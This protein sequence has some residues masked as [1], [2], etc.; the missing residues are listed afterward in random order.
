MLEV[1]SLGSGSCGNALLVRTPGA[2]LLIDCGVGIRRLSRE[3][4]TWGLQPSD[5][6]AVLISHE[7]GDHVRE[8]SRFATARVP[9]LATAGTAGA[10]PHLLSRPE[11]IRYFNPVHVADTEI[12]AIPVSHDAFEPCGFLVRTAHGTVSLF[13]DLGAPSGAIAEAIS[14]SDLVVLEANHDEAMVRRGPYTPQLKRRILAPT[15]HLS[16]QDCGELLVSA[17]KG[18]ARCPEIRLAHLS[19]TNNQPEL[20]QRTVTRRLARER[21]FVGVAVLPRQ[22]QSTIWRSD[23]ASRGVSQLS[24][25]LFA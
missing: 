15:G 6:D 4:A 14:E 8:L 12:V 18:T 7:H 5:V 19:A 9:V 22:E 10:L 23:A 3:L 24:M 17:L 20:A 2:A 1:I 25:D 16:N 21:L 11:I 13:T